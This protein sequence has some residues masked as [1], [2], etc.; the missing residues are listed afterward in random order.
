[1][2]GEDTYPKIAWSYKATKC[3]LQGKENGL[4]KE[5]WRSVQD[6]ETL[7]AQGREATFQLHLLPFIFLF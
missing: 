5:V 6:G 2:N 4:C 3:T 1:M 7:K